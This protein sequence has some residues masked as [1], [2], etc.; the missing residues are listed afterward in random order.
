VTEDIRELLGDNGD[1]GQGCTRCHV[2]GPMVVVGTSTRQDAN[3]DSLNSL[4]CL[5]LLNETGA[6][7]SCIMVSTC[8]LQCKGFLQGF[9]SKLPC[10]TI[11]GMDPHLVSEVVACGQVQTDFHTTDLLHS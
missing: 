8:F 9:A 11:L 1:G 4:K 3:E 2:E 7:S 6:S 10:G 5:A